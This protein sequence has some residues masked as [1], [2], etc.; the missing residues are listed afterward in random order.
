MTVTQLDIFEAFKNATGVQDWEVK[1]RPATEI[2][3]EGF[4]KLGQNDFSGIVGV[5]D[6][7]LVE[8]GNGSNFS[9][10]RKLENEELGV[11]DDLN[12]SVK[13]YVDKL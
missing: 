2:R 12:E 6:A 8:A 7:S 5:I 9:A 10:H 11:R 3:N 13:A 1:H 4:Q